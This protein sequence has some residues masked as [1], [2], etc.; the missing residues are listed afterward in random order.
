M[1]IDQKMVFVEAVRSAADIPIAVQEYA[2]DVDELRQT[3]MD[4]SYLAFLDEQIRLCPR[5][6]EWNA[7]L[8]KRRQMLTGFVGKVLMDGIVR[9]SGKT[10]FIK[11]DPEGKRVLY[12]EDWTG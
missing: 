4:E 5:G 2:G 9:A 3:I 7:V 8:K 1:M 11:I 10:V 12:W 6:E